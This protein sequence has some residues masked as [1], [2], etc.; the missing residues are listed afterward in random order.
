[1]NCFALLSRGNRCFFEVTAENITA[2]WMSERLDRLS[3]S[4]KQV[5]VIV[6]DNARIHTKAVKDR[7]AVGKSEVCLYG[8]CRCILRN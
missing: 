2:H 8:F 4:L 1:M 7:G 3:L 6:L 5:T